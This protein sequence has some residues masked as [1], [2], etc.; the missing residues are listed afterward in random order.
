MNA[1]S[2][3]HMKMKPAVGIGHYRPKDLQIRVGITDRHAFS[4][5]GFHGVED[6]SAFSRTLGVEGRVR[7]LPTN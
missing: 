6:H 5:D 1:N 3:N 4:R 2:K 7:N